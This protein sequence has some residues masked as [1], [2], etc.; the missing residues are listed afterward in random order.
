[1]LAQQSLFEDFCLQLR[2]VEIQKTS[3]VRFCKRKLL[4]MFEHA[5]VKAVQHERNVDINVLVAFI[6]GKGSAFGCDIVR[7]PATE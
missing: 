3:Q 4:T 5:T 7:T 1:L 6:L 2:V